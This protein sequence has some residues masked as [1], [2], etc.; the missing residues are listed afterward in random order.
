M[1]MP[2]VN[3]VVLIRKTAV[4]FAGCFGI[5]RELLVDDNV[6]VEIRLHGGTTLENFAG[7][8]IIVVGPLPDPA[9][10]DERYVA[11]SNRE[12]DRD[13]CLPTRAL[14]SPGLR[15]KGGD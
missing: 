9:A 1:T 3:D 4:N 13:G 14:P 8:D 5:V 6:S 7:I 10:R 15:G 12:S 11:P 2:K